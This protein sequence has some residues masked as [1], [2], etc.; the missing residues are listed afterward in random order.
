ME[1]QLHDRDRVGVQDAVLLEDF[2]NQDVFVDNL[3]KRFKEHVIYTYIGPVLISVNPYMELNIYDKKSVKEYHNKHFFEVPPHI[4]AITNTAYTSLKDENREQCILISGESGSG[5]TEASKKV[6]QYIAEVTDHRGEVEKCK[7]KLIFSNPILEA[8]GN[9]KTNRNDNS[10]RFGKYMDIQFNFEGNPVGGNILNYL[11]EKSRVISQTPGERNFHIF[12][13]LLAGAN[14]DELNKLDLKRSLSSYYYLSSGQQNGSSGIN[15][16]KDFKEVKKALSTLD[17]TENEQMDLFAIISAI[18]HMGNIGFTEEEGVSFIAKPEMVENVSK[19]L[20]CDK[21]L[22]KQALLE[23]TIKTNNEELT[24]PLNRDLSVY[25]RDALAKAVYDRVFTWLVKKI[26]KSLQPKDN[27]R[28]VVMGIL[29]IYGFEIFERN[30]FEQLCINFCNEKLQQLFID[31]TLKSEQDEYEKEGIKW[32]HVEYFDNKI[33]CDLIEEKHKGLIAYMDDECLRP[34]DPNDITLL[35]KLDK[36]LDYHAHYISHKKADIKLQKIMGRDEFRL[37]HYAGAVTYNVKSFIDKNNDL[38]FRDLREAMIRSKNGILQS[39]FLESEQQSKKRPET[40]ITQFKYSVNNLMNILKDKEPSYIRCIKPNDSK[41]SDVFDFELVSHQV[42]YLGLMENLRVRRA[43]FAYRRDYQR[44]LKRYKCLCKETWPNYHGDAKDGVTK[45]I[46]ALKFTEDEYQMGKTKIFIRHP[47]TLFSTEDAFQ[48]K[49]HEIAAIIQSRWK[50]MVQRKK[51]LKMRESAIVVQKHIRRVLAKREAD[52]RRKAAFTI[53]RFIKGF[54]T[55][56]DA[57][58]DDNRSFLAM[59]KVEWLKRLAKN[60]PKHILRRTWPVPPYVCREASKKLESMYGAHMS[61]IYRLQLTPERKRHL[62]LKVLA[63]RIF[64]GKKK[65]Y[66]DSLPYLFVE[67]RVLEGSVPFKELYTSQLNGE[68][69]VYSSNVVKFDR[70]GYK[71]R[72]RLMVISKQKFHL[73]DTKGSLKPKHCIP[74]NSLSFIITPEND[75]LLLV[76]IPEDLIKKDKGDLILQVP[77]LIEALTM[78]I[79][80]VKDEKILRIVDKSSIEHNMKGKHGTIDIQHGDV[81][82][83][84]KDKS[85]HLLIVVSP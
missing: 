84:H 20:N 79:D 64:K 57:P 5:K 65:N 63:E 28:N 44:F 2:N 76:Q 21:N 29:D 35:A 19:L 15:D 39:V 59:A 8:F 40:A 42:T 58:S 68:K 13:Q 43:G 51:Y 72:D 41:R 30:S 81:P 55:R 82:K 37:I 23:R 18:L 48:L 69:E 85:G 16:E 70:H 14:E 71:P 1:H 50:G 4:F 33:I 56:N 17:F 11:L 10:S 31:L 12:Y 53:R 34:G 26:N 32:Q 22:L 7:D 67:E 83:I 75:D 24:T 36:Y 78:I 54:I 66:P 61:R 47:K 46:A 74:L 52:R 6:L 38:L 49:K 77:N 45:L 62:E 80:T 25:A 3:Q 73:L 60:L 9:A 27:R